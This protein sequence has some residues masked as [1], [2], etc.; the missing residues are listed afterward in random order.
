[1]LDTEHKAGRTAL[2]PPGFPTGVLKVTWGLDPRPPTCRPSLL[3]LSELWPLNQK[4]SQLGQMEHLSADGQVVWRTKLGTH[5][6][7]GRAATSLP[8]EGKPR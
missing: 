3:S 4:Q 5:S 6:E 7:G 2:D 8:P 1:M